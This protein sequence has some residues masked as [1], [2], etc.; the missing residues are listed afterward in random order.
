MTNRQKDIVSQIQRYNNF[1][2]KRGIISREEIIER[3]MLKLFEFYDLPEYTFEFDRS[4][5][6]AGCCYCNDKNKRITLSKHFCEMNSASEIKD[7]ML[8]EIA[9]AL[10]FKFFKRSSHTETWKSICRRI[11]ARPDVLDSSLK[12]PKMQHK[13][14]CC[15]CGKTWESHRKMDVKKNVCDCN[16]KLVLVE[17]NKK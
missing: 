15:S 5:T 16:G 11:G 7:T 8:H 17:K 2:F 4:K 10:D 1:D 6:W 9:H 3:E 13:Y 12:M 14:I